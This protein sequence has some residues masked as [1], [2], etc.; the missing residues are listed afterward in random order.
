[1]EILEE[2]NEDDGDVGDEDEGWYR[3]ST[4]KL[5]F[6]AKEDEDKSSCTPKSL[7]PPAK[8]SL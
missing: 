2:D 8:V 3:Q 6:K 7:R 4:L 5:F 1:M